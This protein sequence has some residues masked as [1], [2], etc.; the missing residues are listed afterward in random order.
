[1]REEVDNILRSINATIERDLSL[2]EDKEKN[3]RILLEEIEKRLKVY[4]KEIDKPRA[5]VDTYTAL[6]PKKPPP[7]AAESA[8]VYAGPEKAGPA[9]PLPVFSVKPGAETP[10]APSVGEQIRSLV[11]EGFP[12]P[13]IA[14]RLGISIAEVEFA[15]ALLERQE[16]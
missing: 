9:F 6:S 12:P 8:P 13:A 5:A 4:I 14:S 11:R 10:P 3:L 15:A 7:Q 1:M 16:N 2:L